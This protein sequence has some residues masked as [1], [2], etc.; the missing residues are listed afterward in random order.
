M[1]RILITGGAGYVGSLLTINLEKLGHEVLIYDTC[2]Y[3]KDHIK[4]SVKLKTFSAAPINNSARPAPD[5]AAIIRLVFCILL[6]L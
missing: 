6:P 2:Y 1:S 3:G 4:T 5:N